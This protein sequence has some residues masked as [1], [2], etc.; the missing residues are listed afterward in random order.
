MFYEPYIPEWQNS[1][2]A[3][4]P[5]QNINMANYGYSQQE[6]IWLAYWAGKRRMVVGNNMS[7]ISAWNGR[8]RS[9]K[10]LN[11]T[12]VGYLSDS[13]FWDRYEH[14]LVREPSEFMSEIEY[15]ARHKIKGAYFQIDEA[16]VSMANSGWYELWGKTISSTIQMVGYLNPMIAIVAPMN[17]FVLS[18][19]RRMLNNLYNVS[20]YNNEVSVVKPYRVMYSTMFRRYLYPRP[21]MKFAGQRYI[22]NKLTA[23]LPPKFIVDRYISIMESAKTEK[24]AQLAETL[25]ASGIQEKTEVPFD[26]QVSFLVDNYSLFQAKTSKEDSI[27]LDTSLIRYRMAKSGELP[28][29]K[30]RALKTE[31]ERRLMDIVKKKKEDIAAGKRF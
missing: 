10:S 13:T 25:K 9:G 11:A 23:T 5:A 14:R 31:A 17:E 30:A 7:D 1:K 20:R 15:V 26:D 2:F 21:V 8:H 18:A 27:I 22:I 12:D 29:R 24:I 4:D 28:D 6:L 3:H 16:G 19:L